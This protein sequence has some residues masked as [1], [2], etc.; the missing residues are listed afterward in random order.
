MSQKIDSGE[1]FNSTLALVG[2]ESKG[3]LFMK[4]YHAEHVQISVT[5]VDGCPSAPRV[6]VANQNRAEFPPSS[7]S[8]KSCKKQTQSFGKA[9]GH[10][11]Q[12]LSGQDHARHACTAYASGEPCSHMTCSVSQP[13]NEMVAN[14]STNPSLVATASPANKHD[15]SK[16][17]EYWKCHES[18]SLAA[19]PS[20]CGPR[21]FNH[22]A[23]VMHAIH[24]YLF[25]VGS[26]PLFDAPSLGKENYI[27][28]PM[29]GNVREWV[30]VAYNDEDLP[31]GCYPL[32]LVAWLLGYARKFCAKFTSQQLWAE[33]SRFKPLQKS[34]SH[35]RKPAFERIRA[36]VRG[37]ST[38][39][40]VIT[41]TSDIGHGSK[42]TQRDVVRSYKLEVEQRWQSMALYME[43]LV[44]GT[45]RYDMLRA[46]FNRTSRTI[47][48]ESPGRVRNKFRRMG[49]S[50]PALPST[51]SVVNQKQVAVQQQVV[52]DIYEVPVGITCQHGS[53][54]PSNVLPSKMIGRI[55]DYE[56]GV[57]QA[58]KSAA[59]CGDGTHLLKTSIIHTND[60]RLHSSV[61]HQVMSIERA[62][63]NPA[64]LNATM[65]IADDLEGNN[66]REWT[67]QLLLLEGVFWADC[68]TANGRSRLA[69][70]VWL[71]DRFRTLLLSQGSRTFPVMEVDGGEDLLR[72]VVILGPDNKAARLG[73]E[74][75]VVLS[76]MERTVYH[77]HP[78]D[79]GQR[80]AFAIDIAYHCMDGAALAIML[81]MVYGS[82][83][84]SIR[85]FHS[86]TESRHCPTNCALDGQPVVTRGYHEF[87]LDNEAVE[88]ITVLLMAHECSKHNAD[89]FCFIGLQ[90]WRTF[91][92]TPSLK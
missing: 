25:F 81:G 14:V 82:A 68:F 75:N 73:H 5:N 23:C 11:T 4:A 47:G 52:V 9:L 79:D 45:N 39:Q 70:L 20:I 50:F 65:K 28:H 51:Q 53:Q 87:Q 74:L 21:K 48:A 40:H 89:L 62:L 85:A 18:K 63:G 92:A 59:S 64:W 72:D 10:E 32:T 41:I 37:C 54:L 7:C 83:A 91:A 22:Y 34:T 15:T 44:G 1:A 33:F 78:D 49:V 24:M 35:L 84:R 27:A 19:A 88:A 36:A 86:Y 29:K 8:T 26:I 46:A 56:L 77:L 16:F 60:Q 66:M 69:A 3:S 90:S 12:L 43:R 67:G 55:Q 57:A 71:V 76:C 6:N 2:P 13:D 31:E 17:V 58:M 42:N 61:M 38:L 80:R 30:V